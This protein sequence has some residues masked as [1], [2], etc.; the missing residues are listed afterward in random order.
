MVRLYQYNIAQKVEIIVEHF[1]AKVKYL[2]SG[3]VKARVVTSSRLEAV[4]YKLA[5][6]KYVQDKGYN[7][8]HA[9]MAFSGEVNNPDFPDQSCT[10]NNMNLNLRGRDMRKAFDTFDTVDYQVM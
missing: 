7:N 10:V 1:N 5:F 9:M 4:R 3:K 8:V 2:F 6:E